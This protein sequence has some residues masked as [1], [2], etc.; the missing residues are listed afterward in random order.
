MSTRDEKAKKLG[1][2]AAG[3]TQKVV[4]GLKEALG[5]GDWHQAGAHYDLLAEH[6]RL[7]LIGC[8]NAARG[9]AEN[10]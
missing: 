7:G 5:K 8:K 4:D 10:N 3:Q 6:A 2:I 1:L 9:K